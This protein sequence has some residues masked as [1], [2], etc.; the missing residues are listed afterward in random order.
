MRTSVLCEQR[1]AA[2]AEAEAEAARQEWIL[3]RTLAEA[4]AWRVRI[5]FLVSGPRGS[6][7]WEGLRVRLRAAT[8][9]P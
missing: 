9:N 6:G 8:N 2:E 4:A 5:Q 7:F 1:Q 3:A